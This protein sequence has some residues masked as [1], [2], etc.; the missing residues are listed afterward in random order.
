MKEKMLLSFLILGVLLS[1]CGY[2][3][4][5]VTYKED[6]IFIAPVKNEVDITSESR[7]FNTYKTF[8]ILLEK[9]LTNTLVEKFNIDG[10][11]KV[12]SVSE[13]ALKLTCVI[14]DY[15]KEALR[16]TDSEDI[17]E[18]RLRLSVDM[19]LVDS[20]GAVLK[21]KEVKGE[22]T[23][24]LTGSHRKSESS[25]RQDLIDDTA[26]RILETIIEEW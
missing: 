4:S 17:E 12:T 9:N 26:R 20:A 5:G 18:Q 3:T 7:R 15:R 11:L 8:P 1:G 13:G 25:A 22:T 24:Y 16:Y 2:A 14:K 10:H 21:E 6:S 19:K 23:F